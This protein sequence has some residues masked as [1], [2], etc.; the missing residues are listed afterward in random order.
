[1]Q[2]NNIYTIQ[3]ILPL[4]ESGLR[5]KLDHEGQEVFNYWLG[6]CILLAIAYRE[7]RLGSFYL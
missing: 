5:Q 3:K 1:M 4:T 2:T 7:P 6:V